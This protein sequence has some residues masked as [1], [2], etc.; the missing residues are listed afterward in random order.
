MSFDEKNMNSDFNFNHRVVLQKNTQ[1]EGEYGEINN[2]IDI[3]A[4]V[5]ANI[6]PVKIKQNFLQM[7][8]DVE[9][10]HII[11]IRYREDAKQCKT[12]IY[13]N[14]VFEVIGVI[15]PDEKYNTLEFQVKELV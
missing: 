8:N 1:T 10:S 9:I 13:N 4:E 12:I 6:E 14:R 2:Y 15:S 7:K 3:I 5:W 11:T